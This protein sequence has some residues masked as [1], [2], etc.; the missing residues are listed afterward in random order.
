MTKKIFLTLLFTFQLMGALM[1]KLM[2]QM[3]TLNQHLM[4][5]VIY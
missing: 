4:N 3:S 2:F 1:K 5:F